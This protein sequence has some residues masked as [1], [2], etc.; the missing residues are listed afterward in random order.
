M[1]GKA[2]AL[3]AII[4]LLLLPSGCWDRRETEDLL[5]VDSIVFG[6][7]NTG[8]TGQYRISFI[9]A[10][11][12]SGGGQMGTGGGTDGQEVAAQTATQ[13]EAS[14]YGST[15][16]EA[17]LKFSIRSPRHI[18]LA[19]NRIIM[20]EEDLAKEGI[21]QV[22]DFL[23]RSRDI[24]LRNYVLVVKGH[25]PDL[26]TSSPEF[27][28]TLAGELFSILETS[29]GEGDYYYPSDLNIIAQG[30]LTNG[31]DPWAPFIETFSAAQAS[32]RSTSQSVIIRGTALFKGDRLV[33]YLDAEETQRFLL[34]KGLS[35]TGIYNIERNG[36]KLSYRYEQAKV[37]RR[38]TVE[39]GRINVH[40]DIKLKGLLEEIHFYTN[41]SEAEMESLEKV[42]SAKAEA[43]LL[44][45]VN[46]CKELESDV[47]GIGR[48]IHSRKPEIW[49]EISENWYSI[50]PE[51]GIDINVIAQIAGTALGSKPIVPKASE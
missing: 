37:K 4:S 14:S 24:R 40:F 28:D 48:L 18:Y 49:K 44:E 11:P 45:T 50:Y 8:D 26:L 23:I 34:L 13:W 41:L 2:L 36:R 19:H 25:E 51:I 17:I 10:R 42:L 12:S 5:L 6:K 46:R 22:V 32:V 47:L 7:S 16:E 30:I 27:E 3:L 38:L 35:N 9:T 20:F 29:I 31:Q 1:A 21:S 15:L 39:D 33:G 43:V